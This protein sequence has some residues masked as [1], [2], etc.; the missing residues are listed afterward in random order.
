MKLKH[1]INS[2]KW[3]L[4]CHMHLVNI[5]HVWGVIF[6]A[7]HQD[8][9][10]YNFSCKTYLQNKNNRIYS[11]IYVNFLIYFVINLTYI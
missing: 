1:Y 9:M 7:D 3:G 4:T 5:L 8:T 2:T 6:P 10:T 11:S